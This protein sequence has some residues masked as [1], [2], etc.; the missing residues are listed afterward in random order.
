MSHSDVWILVGTASFVVTVGVYVI[1]I[2]ATQYT[3]PPLN[4]LV[5]KER[6]CKKG[7]WYGWVPRLILDR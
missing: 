7:G 1:V 5:R 6:R 4:T 3:R 2:K